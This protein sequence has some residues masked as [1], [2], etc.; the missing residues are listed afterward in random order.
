MSGQLLTL[1]FVSPYTSRK[2]RISQILLTKCST[3]ADILGCRLCAR[4]K[5]MVKILSVAMLQ[6]LLIVCIGVG[7]AGGQGGGAGRL[8]HTVRVAQGAPGGPVSAFVTRAL[9]PKP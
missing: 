6:T 9:Y 1:L 7:A 2:L 3:A 5:N 4:S 8:Q